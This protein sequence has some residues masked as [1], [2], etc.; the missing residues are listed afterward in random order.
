MADLGS[1][2]KDARK[3]V[4]MSQEELASKVGLDRSSIIAYE[5][6]EGNPGFQVVA[7]IAAALREP[8]KVL[9]CRIGP[10]DVPQLPPAAEQ[11]SLAFD[12]DHVFLARLSIRPSQKSL[13]VTAVAQLGDKLA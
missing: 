7:Q 3:K 8:F 9:G 4:G 6:G 5:K 2:I 11:L 13:S 1:Q 12:Q 10:E